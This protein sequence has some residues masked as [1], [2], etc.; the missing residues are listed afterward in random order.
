MTIND[1]EQALLFMDTWGS[2][3]KIE[4]KSFHGYAYNIQDFAPEFVNGELPERCQHTFGG[5][6]TLLGIEGGTNDPE[7][8]EG[9]TLAYQYPAGEK[10]CPCE[11]QEEHNEDCTIC[12]GENIIYWGEEWSVFVLVPD[13]EPDESDEESDDEPEDEES[14]DEEIE[15]EED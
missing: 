10:R 14:E 15:D 2:G 3:D 13:E 8:I 5:V 9:Y 1:N 4:E 12:E 7:S 11:D 6:V